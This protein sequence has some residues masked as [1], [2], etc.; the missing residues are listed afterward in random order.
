MCTSSSQDFFSFF[1]C[2]RSSQKASYFNFQ[3]SDSS[4]RLDMSQVVWMKILFFL[5][6]S[7]Q[8]S[9]LFAI[10]EVRLLFF[11]SRWIFSFLSF[12]ISAY[13]WIRA[14]EVKSRL[15]SKA[16]IF[17]FA[18]ASFFSAEVFPD[19]T[20]DNSDLRVCTSFCNSSFMMFSLL[21][22]ANLSFSFSLSYSTWGQFTNLYQFSSFNT[23]C[24]S[25][26]RIHVTLFFL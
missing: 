23:N 1:S 22:S 14:S 21:I 10:S 8:E 4:S 3:E 26:L 20:E 2:S 13:T 5:N 17:F 12:C 18:S 7:F 16:F 9:S 25:D 6:F 15:T 24:F 11:F 19:F